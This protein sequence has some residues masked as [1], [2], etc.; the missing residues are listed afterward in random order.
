[1]GFCG[2]ENQQ[3]GDIVLLEAEF[4]DEVMVECKCLR[5]RAR[6]EDGKTGETI[7]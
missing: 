1:M 5:K 6:E 2:F 4:D 3:Y 7:Q